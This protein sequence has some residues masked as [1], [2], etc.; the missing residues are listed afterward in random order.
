MGGRGRVCY[1]PVIRRQ[2]ACNTGIGRAQ[3]PVALMS[4]RLDGLMRVDAAGP[5]VPSGGTSDAA[6][7]RRI[8]SRQDGSTKA[9]DAVAGGAAGPGRSARVREHPTPHGCPELDITSVCLIMQYAVADG[10]GSDAGDRYDGG[11]AAGVHQ[12]QLLPRQERSSQTGNHGT[13][14]PYGRGSPPC[15]RGPAP[16]KDT[17]RG[18]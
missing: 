13:T 5:C 4:L 16:G 2:L 18:S 8:R 9:A 7:R 11:C 1:E 10:R 3:V 14:P 17:E 15:G 12:L 6:R